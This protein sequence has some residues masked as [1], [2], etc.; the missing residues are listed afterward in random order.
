MSDEERAAILEELSPGYVI[1]R[2]ALAAAPFVFCSPHSGRC[3]PRRFLTQSRLDAHTLRRSEDCYVDRLFAAAVEHGVPLLSARFPRA[4]LDV[5]REPYELDPALFRETLPDYANRHSTRVV[6]GLGTIARIVA[7]GAEIYGSPLALE[8]GLA[9]IE[10]LYAPFHAA[11]DALLGETR[12]AFGYAVLIDCHSMPSLALAGHGRS[13]PDI[14]LGD[15]FGTS[16][17][18][19]ITG[20]V[21]EAFLA[22]GYDVRINRPYAGGF[23]TEHYG[24][25]L[26]DTHALQIEI[27]RGLYLD[28]KSLEPRAQFDELASDLGAIIADIV[29]GLPRLLERR[30][31]AE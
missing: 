24:K 25:P 11:L 3:Y 15:R 6:G 23:I 4:Y 29:S 10:L 31:A 30:A 21:R 27:N 7:D 9:R 1:E 28:E 12:A 19:L 8:D 17:S 2:P 16:C 18:G 20:F 22:H 26:A 13:R 14:V 5:N